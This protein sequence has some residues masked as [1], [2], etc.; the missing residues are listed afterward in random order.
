MLSSELEKHFQSAR[1]K[2][3]DLDRFQDKI[4]KYCDEIERQNTIIS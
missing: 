3:N 4:E 1:N 2:C